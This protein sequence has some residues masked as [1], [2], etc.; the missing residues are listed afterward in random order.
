MRELTI[1]RLAEKTGVN[2]ET[3][4]YYERIG[5]MP[6]PER[7]AGGHRSYTEAQARRLAFIRRARELGFSLDEIRTLLTLSEPGRASCAEVQP[8][9]QAHLESVRAKRADLARLER[10]LADT[11]SRCTGTASPE[12][13][14]LDMLKS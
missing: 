7:T 4:R 6:P 12:C 5:L 10:I 2:L 3:V 14:V 11:V 13:P 9:A 8:I 1:G